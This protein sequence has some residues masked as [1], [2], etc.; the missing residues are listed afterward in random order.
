MNCPICDTPML[1]HV[2]HFPEICELRKENAELRHDL[3]KANGNH[4]SDLN[5]ML[6]GL[7]S[8]WQNGVVT[9]ACRPVGCGDGD[10]FV[11]NPFCKAHS[12]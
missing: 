9:C 12:R 5:G 4:V 8:E 2:E 11:P 10:T 1:P 6:S 7:P 3:E